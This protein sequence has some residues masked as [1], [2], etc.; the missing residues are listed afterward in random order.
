MGFSLDMFQRAR[1]KVSDLDSQAGKSVLK[2]LD[3]KLGDKLFWAKLRFKSERGNFY[4][5]LAESMRRMPGRTT[6]DFLE[7]YAQRY[8]K[9]PM[10][11]LA[12]H[13]LERFAHTG[14]F[15]E[16]IR[17]SV[18]PED[19]TVLSVSEKNGDL[20]AGLES[21]G[22]G[23]Q[24][25]AA[26]RKT[27]NGALASA[28]FLVL[29][30]HLFLAI[31]AWMVL[32]KLEDAVKANIDPRD[33]G[34][35]ATVFFT[36][37][38]VIRADWWMW[39]AFVGI[40]AGWVIWSLPR[41]TGRVRAWLDK[42]V[43]FYQIYRDFNSAQFF[44]SLG[45]V[46]KLI[47]SQI[48]QV[49]DALKR[50]RTNATPWLKWHIDAI[51]ANMELKPNSRGEVFDTGL[52]NRSMYYRILDI[53]EYAQTSEM[54]AVVGELILEKAPL[55]IKQRATLMR[56]GIMVVTIV[57]MMAIYGGTILIIEDFKEQ[58]QMKTLRMGH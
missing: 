11:K 30:M 54:L 12:A 42:H 22:K 18:P 43:L 29:V 48:M 16:A 8:A 24:G 31:Q 38:D 4:L 2:K 50:M 5:D 27:V 20:R 46:T 15:Y 41:Y 21:L 35:V 23:I 13:W 36:S 3:A 51:L 6:S 49:S 57:L 39:V 40:V 9:M 44:V 34:T 56:Y 37:G 45:S 26:C 47:G 10:G 1:S 28:V 17:D 25:M 55:E 58:V 52:T 33:M 53:G 19:I 7:K 14:Y 32:P